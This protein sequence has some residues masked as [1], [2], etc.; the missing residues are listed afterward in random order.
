MG[1]FFIKIYKEQIL[2]QIE[3]AE[4]TYQSITNPSRDTDAL[5]RNIHYFMIH[6]S[7]V[8]KLIQ[9]K[10]SNDLDFKNYRMK[11]LKRKYPNIPDIDPRLIRI[12]NDFEHYDERIDSWIINSKQHNYADKNLSN[13]NP[14]IAIGG[15]NPKDSFR[16]YSPNTKTLYF[17]GEEY[18]LDELYFYI[19][20]VKEALD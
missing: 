19:Q 9:P 10:I 5:F 8:V 13:V 2:D 14:T 18:L 15:L 11:Q 17:C 1:E 7:N 20:K 16:C 6:I 4:V 12:R 3:S